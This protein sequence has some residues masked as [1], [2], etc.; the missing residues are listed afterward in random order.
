MPQMI[1]YGGELIR[2]NPSNNHIEYSSTQGR[3]WML[4]YSGS[5]NGNF[6]DLLPYGNEL[7]AVTSKGIY[8]SSTAGR[9]WM[10]RY[11]G[12]SCGNFQMLQ[13]GGRELLGIS[14][15]GLYYSTTAGRSWMFRHK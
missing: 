10:L 8:Y 6:I 4:R 11:S 3:S 15:K 12:S 2:I 9:S 13:D 14:D 7:L 5:S 1:T